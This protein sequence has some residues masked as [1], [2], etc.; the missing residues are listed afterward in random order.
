MARRTTDIAKLLTEHLD[1][2]FGYALFITGDRERAL[3]LLQD[4]AVSLIAKKDLPY[5]E[6]DAF[7]AWL[8]RVLRNNWLNRVSRDAARR[9]IPDSD[10]RRADDDEGVIPSAVGEEGIAGDPLLRDRV[11]A[12]F[13]QLPED[14]QEVCYLVDVE[15]H[16]YDEVARLLNIPIG[17]V[18]SRLHRGREAL[19]AKLLR[20]AGELR[21]VPFRKEEKDGRIATL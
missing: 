18:M 13:S 4:T 14:F 1:T 7:R 2:M 10:L 12:A 6:R 21:I 8:F 11:T 20:E 15:G 16:A 9:E 3:D 19:K 5:E 17:T